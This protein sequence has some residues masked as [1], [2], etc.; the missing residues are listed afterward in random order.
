MAQVRPRGKLRGTLLLIAL[1]AAASAWAAELKVVVLHGEEPVAGALVLLHS[2]PAATPPIPVDAVMDQIGSQFVPRLLVVPV[3][4][5]V[6]FPNSDITRHQVYSFSPTKRFDLPLYSG[7]PP[8]PVV[9]ERPGVV[10]LGCNIHDWMVGYIAVVDTPH[11]L[12]T[13]D[14]GKA[15]GIF[16]NGRYQLDV[17]HERRQAAASQAGEHLTL[18]NDTVLH[19][20]ELD[21]APPPPPRGDERM[22]ALQ[23]KFRSLK[24]D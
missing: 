18:D 16:P 2:D 24:R 5:R 1:C 20:I 6:A 19:S 13:D 4:S 11:Y 17:W 12:V 22:R 7:T 21:L 3:G 14:E 8:Q 10:T 9:F 23:E 15:S